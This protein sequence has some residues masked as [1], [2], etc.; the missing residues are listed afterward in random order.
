MEFGLTP[1]ASNWHLPLPQGQA[2]AYRA[3]TLTMG[4]VQSA[5]AIEASAVLHEDSRPKAILKLRPP[6]SLDDSTRYGWQP[7]C[8]SLSGTVLLIILAE[9]VDKF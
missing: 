6:D 2:S 7:T 5:D 8:A 3:L 1:V 9:I 4:L